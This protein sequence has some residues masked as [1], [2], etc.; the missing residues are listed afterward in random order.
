MHKL[1]CYQQQ[2]QDGGVRIAVTVDDATVFHKFEPGDEE[3]SDPAL[4]WFVDVR[5]FG[6]QLPTEPED[7]RQWLL[8]QEPQV[9]QGL[10]G[11]AEKLQAGLD[12]EGWPLEYKVPTTVRGLKITIVCSAIHRVTCLD[13][14]SILTRIRDEWKQTI[15]SL[16]KVGQKAG[17]W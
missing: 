16:P 14:A 15:Q 8:D 17:V 10:T 6:K 7:A 2:R 9:R 13:I 11:L 1:T 4:E 12:V 5:F 3:N